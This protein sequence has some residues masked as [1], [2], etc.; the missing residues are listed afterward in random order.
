MASECPSYRAIARAI[1][2]TPTTVREWLDKGDQPDSPELFRTFSKAI[3]GAISDGERALT[4]K[5]AAGEARDAAWLLTHSPF[6]RGEW[7][8]AAAERKT[9]RRTV[10]TVLEAVAAAEL[11]ADLERNLLLQMQARGLGS[12]AV[13]GE[14]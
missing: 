2:V 12:K 10:G 1:G 3:H 7:S 6:F 4:R 9:E 11:P 14:S 8:D 5:I 13:E